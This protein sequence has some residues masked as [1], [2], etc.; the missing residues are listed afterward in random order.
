MKRHFILNFIFLILFYF[1]NSVIFQV[2]C[3]KTEMEIAVHGHITTEILAVADKN[4]N[5]TLECGTVSFSVIIF[6]TF[7]NFLF[8]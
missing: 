5:K 7:L 8:Y 2:G 3:N 6:L 1:I 4:K